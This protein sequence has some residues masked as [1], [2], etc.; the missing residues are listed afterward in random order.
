MSVT[1]EDVRKSI[2]SMVADMI[3]VQTFLAEV[4]SVDSSKRTCT[5]KGLLD[6]LEMEDVLLGV[7]EGEGNWNEPEQNSQVMVSII[8]NMN[9]SGYVSMFSKVKAVWMSTEGGALFS[10]QDD[11]KVRLNGDAYAGIPKLQELE[12]NLDQLKQYVE[13]MK[14]AIGPAFAAVGASTAANGAAG[15]A[16]FQ[17]ATA[18][19]VINFQQMENDKVLHGNG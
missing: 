16:S 8:Q 2:R 19:L 11:G 3:P 4:V 15:Q 1:P 7:A 6:E 13:T 12:A 10:L 17:G 5:V 18:S 14:A 9:G